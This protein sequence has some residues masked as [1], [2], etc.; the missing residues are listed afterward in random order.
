MSSKHAMQVTAAC[1]APQGG[2]V[3]RVLHL[4]ALVASAHVHRALKERLV[5]GSP[6]LTRVIALAMEWQVET[7]LH[8]AARAQPHG[9][10]KHVSLRSAPGQKI[11][12]PVEHPMATSLELVGGKPL[13]TALA[14]MVGVARLVSSRFAKMQRI[15]AVMVK[16]QE[17]SQIVRALVKQDMLAASVNL[18]YAQTRRTATAKV[19][20]TRQGKRDVN[21]YASK[22]GREPNVIRSC[23]SL[24]KIA[25]IKAM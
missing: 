5:N 19:L 23:A 4:K 3:P 16:Q 6:A 14:I 1:A 21:V 18:R 20:R 12:T 10:V 22:G 25:V 17:I 9:Q 7:V 2:P 13:A 15:A 8:V 24:Q 11:V